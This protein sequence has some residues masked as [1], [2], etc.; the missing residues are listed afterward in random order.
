MK[1]SRLLTRSLSFFAIAVMLFSLFT[2]FPAAAEAPSET[3]H[4][5]PVTGAGGSSY[6]IF[7]SGRTGRR[8]TEYKESKNY[9]ENSKTNG[10]YDLYSDYYYSSMRNITLGRSFTVLCEVDEVAELAVYAYDIDESQGEK[11]RIYLVDE[12]TGTAQK[13]GLLSGMDESWNNTTFRIDPSYFVTVHTY[14]FELT[15]E[16]SGWVSWVRNVT[17]TVNGSDLGDGSAPVSSIASASA[18]AT[19][20][21]SGAVRVDVTATGNETVTVDLEVK[22]TAV[23]TEAQHAQIFTSV[24]VTPEQSTVS[25]TVNLEY[26]APTGIYRIDV[27]FKNPGVGNVIKTTTAVAGYRAVAV[28]YH[29]NGGSNNLPIDATVYTYG[30]P[31]T[32]KFDYLPSK[33]GYVFLG[34]AVSI[35]AT[36]PDFLPGSSAAF[37]IGEDDVI[38]YAVWRV[39]GQ[40]HLH[41]YTPVE[42][43]A[44][45][46]QPG[47]AKEVCACG[48]EIHVTEIPARGHDY[49]G[50]LT[51]EPTCHS[52]GTMTYTCSHEGCGDAYE[53]T[54]ITTV[55]HD[56]VGVLTLEPTCH[57]DGT[58]TYTCS[59]EGCGDAYEET[60]ITTVPHDYEILFGASEH[61]ETCSV[62]QA[63]KEGSRGNHSGGT[64]TC[65]AKAV[66]EVCSKLYGKADPTHHA[67]NIYHYE[68]GS[69]GTHKK[70]HDCCGASI[71]EPCFGGKAT[72]VEKALCTLCREP[73]GDLAPHRYDETLWAYQSEAGHAHLCSVAGCGAHGP[74]TAHTSSGAATETAPEI[75]TDCQYVITPALGHTV[76]TP[77]PEW[78]YDKVNHWHDCT[79]CEGQRLNMA[80]HDYDN[81]CDADCNT[82]GAIRTADHTFAELHHDEENHWFACACGATS[83]KMPHF[84]E[85]SNACAICGY[86]PPSESDDQE[87][88]DTTVDTGNETGD[89]TDSEGESDTPDETDTP[90]NADETADESGTDNSQEE[91]EEKKRLFSTIATVVIAAAALII[92]IDGLI[93]L[94]RFLRKKP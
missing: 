81:D 63:E 76:H 50:V 10:G 59:H 42:I 54:V 51:L 31:V 8:G 36:T 77:R 25:H 84:Y 79:G 73:Y 47:I 17:L 70:I 15:H 37:L 13:L 87:E 83:D 93:V 75:C 45:C 23:K 92:L 43:P 12:T 20:T 19:I 74:L 32:V 35:S 9:D 62:C 3:D 72:C 41:E 66:C 2:L 34:W 29:A 11:D 6:V 1:S 89:E 7:A 30:D 82:C 64:A 69:G 52:D 60:V 33:P 4:H 53:E 48:D 55:P 71:D 58:M 85:D 90:A 91:E 21:D 39:E 57:S 26:G 38:L 67:S 27:Y 46:T 68:V 49:V 80:A 28:S 65:I 18:T 14:H 56:Y 94:V 61:W 5:V 24:T 22:V 16:V 86:R 44:T 88:T 78:K 40:E